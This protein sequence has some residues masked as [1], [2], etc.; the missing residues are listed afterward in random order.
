MGADRYHARHPQRNF[1]RAQPKRWR[2]GGVDRVGGFDHLSSPGAPCSVNTH[3]CSPRLRPPTAAPDLTALA[4]TQR[5]VPWWLCTCLHKTL[6]RGQVHFQ[7][8][9]LKMDPPFRNRLAHSRVHRRSA[10]RL[11]WSD[12]RCIAAATKRRAG[13]VEVRASPS[14]RALSAAAP[15]RWSSPSNLP[16]SHLFGGV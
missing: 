5:C 1:M 10:C 3:C 8:L 16:T 4:G 11:T 14:A 7:W 15:K 12:C 9:D 2:A 13:G 6:H